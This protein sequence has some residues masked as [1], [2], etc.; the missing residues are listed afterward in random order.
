LLFLARW[1]PLLRGLFRSTLSARLR[2]GLVLTGLVW[3]RLLLVAGMLVA[4][5]GHRLERSGLEVGV[6]LLA[7]VLLPVV[8]LGMAVLRAAI[9]LVAVVLLVVVLWTGLW[10]TLLLLGMR[11]LLASGHGGWDDHGDFRLVGR[12]HHGTGDL[13]GVRGV[14]R[15]DGVVGGDH[16]RASGSGAGQ[17]RVRPLAGVHASTSPAFGAG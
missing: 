1:L 16:E 12:C 17:C 6:L 2:Y 5:I 7:V 15:R 8:L 4:G 3:T 14:H 13:H 9:V 10:I 11:L